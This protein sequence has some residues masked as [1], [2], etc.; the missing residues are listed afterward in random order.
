[1]DKK[2]IGII[3]LS[4]II[5]FILIF[6]TIYFYHKQQTSEQKNVNQQEIKQE[7]NKYIEVN[8][9]T[10]ASGYEPE[11]P[12]YVERKNQTAQ[13]N[14]EKNFSGLIFKNIMLV[15]LDGTNVFEADVVNDTGENIEITKKSVTLLG[16]DGKEIYSFYIGIA[17]AKNGETKR[18]HAQF[19]DEKVENGIAIDAYDFIVK[20]IE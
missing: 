16:V 3:T 15:K 8:I 14:Q 6:I 11:E 18:V 9:E 2:K 5:I 20:D 17:N 1:M 13:F 10:N 19:A 12:I 7:E 4:I